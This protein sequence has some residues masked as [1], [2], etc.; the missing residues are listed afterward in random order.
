MTVVVSIVA[1]SVGVNIEDWL[2]SLNIRCWCFCFR[3]A[4][5]LLLL[6]LSASGFK[7]Q[8]LGHHCCSF[9]CCTRL[10]FGGLG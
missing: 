9:L 3:V 1:A 4:A 7:V 2:F 5:C 8:D 10:E 6:L